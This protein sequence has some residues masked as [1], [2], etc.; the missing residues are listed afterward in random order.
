MNPFEYV[1]ATDHQSAI[2]A[3][4]RPTTPAQFLAGGTNLIDLMREGIEQPR[5]VIDIS[6]LLL[7][8]VE[9]S[10]RDRRMGTAVRLQYDRDLPPAIL[11]TIVDELELQPE[12]LYEVEGFIAFADLFQLYSAV[13]LPRLKDRPLTPRPVAAFESAPDV[14]TAIRGGD[15][16]VHHPYHA[17]D[18][19]T[20]FVHDAAIDP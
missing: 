18:A 9:E 14:W 7:T 4:A 10:L 16:L 17:F 13:D 1:R 12:D 20:R 8:A 6:R 15:V 3:A 19:V 5:R 2:D 11:A